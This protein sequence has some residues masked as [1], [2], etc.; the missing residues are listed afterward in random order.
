[1]SVCRCVSVSAGTGVGRWAR[2]RGLLLRS[3]QPAPQRAQAP[4]PTQAPAPGRR[5][6]WGGV[7]ARVSAALL[8]AVGPALPFR[9]AGQTDAVGRTGA[10][11]RPR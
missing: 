7:R 1:M 9:A 11:H 3:P 6:T 5:R 2:A 10:R 4:P 8:V